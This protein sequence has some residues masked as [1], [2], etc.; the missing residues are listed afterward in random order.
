MTPMTPI[1]DLP[2]KRSIFSIDRNATPLS[3]IEPNKFNKSSENEIT[4]SRGHIISMLSSKSG[5]LDE[6]CLQNNY[7]SSYYASSTRNPTINSNYHHSQIPFGNMIPNLTSN[8]L[9]S[10]SSNPAA[11][12]RTF[13][14]CYHERMAISPSLNQIEPI[15]SRELTDFRN[16]GVDDCSEIFCTCPKSRC[17]KLY[18]ICFQRGLFCDKEY[19]K[20][21]D[22]KNKLEHNGPDGERTVAITSIL[23]RRHDAFEKREKPM[24]L[25]CNCK[26]NKCLKKY[27]ACF[28]EGTICTYQKCGCLNCH[29]YQLKVSTTSYPPILGTEICRL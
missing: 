24:G 21:F 7:Q 27:C 4:F 2:F 16:A 10:S 3:Q 26:R 13:L 6:N 9:D 19:C 29:N 11:E 14:N 18:C 8:R 23:R 20:C 12:S 15:T 1:D 17:L 28:S 22:C 5:L 25:G